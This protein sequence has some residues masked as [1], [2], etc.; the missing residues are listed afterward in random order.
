MLAGTARKV[1]K[2]TPLCSFEGRVEL[3]PSLPNKT[4]N[5]QTLGEWHEGLNVAENCPASIQGLVV[6]AQGA[7]T[8]GRRKEF[9]HVFLFLATF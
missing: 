3:L 1:A 9:D 4:D 5:L 6:R 2:L 8:G 7:A